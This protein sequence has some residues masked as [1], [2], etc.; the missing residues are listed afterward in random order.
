VGTLSAVHQ[1]EEHQLVE[2]V[3]ELEDRDDDGVLLELLSALHGPPEGLHPVLAVDE[4]EPL[5]VVELQIPQAAPSQVRCLLKSQIPPDV[6]HD[7]GGEAAKLS[8]QVLDDGPPGL[9]EATF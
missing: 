9:P 7:R 8:E 5:I 2:A 3:R 1:V 6:Q 4:P